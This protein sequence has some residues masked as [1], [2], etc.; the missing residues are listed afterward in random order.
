MPYPRHEALHDRE[1][2]RKLYFN[3]NKLQREIAEELGCS[4][5]AVSLAMKRYG[6]RKKSWE[7]KRK[8]REPK[9]SHLRDRSWLYEQYVVSRKSQVEIA[10]QLG[11][12]SGA[13]WK[14]CRKLGIPT[15][16]YRPEHRPELRKFTPDQDEEIAKAYLSGLTL[17]DLAG[18]LH[19]G[20]KAIRSALIRQGVK[21]RH[22]GTK[23]LEIKMPENLRELGYIAGLLDGEGHITWN[24]RKRHGKIKKQPHIGISNTNPE[25]L[26]YLESFGGKVSWRPKRGKFS[27]CGTWQIDGTLNIILF[28]RSVLPSLIIKKE[29]AEEM[30]AELEKRVEGGFTNANN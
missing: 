19:V 1:L 20:I 29:K 9:N 13:V 4:L 12:S 3:Q 11:V 22:L 5:A 2:L 25:V 7:I 18:Q 8:L 15:R 10:R 26:K 30:L 17:Q 6:L 21:F 27:A 28:L 16:K 24:I 14:A 23:G